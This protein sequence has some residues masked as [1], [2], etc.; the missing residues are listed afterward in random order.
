MNDGAPVSLATLALQIAQG[1]L[2]QREK[3][4][5]SN[6]GPMI[7]QYL[8]AVGLNPGYAWCQ[9][10][11]YWCYL[12]AAEQLNIS[13]PVVRTA[14]VLN[15]WNKTAIQFKLTKIEALKDTSLIHPGCQFILN[16]GKGMGHTG[17]VERVKGQTIYTV[18]GNSNSD[19]SREGYAVVRQKRNI[20][21][22]LLAGFIKY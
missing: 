7:D 11:V 9:A 4:M 15:C 18:E 17:I 1:Q 10:F 20:N 19:G 14:G 5:G 3:P 12:Q 2:G 21:S 13:N 6:R 8:A 16:Y 22:A